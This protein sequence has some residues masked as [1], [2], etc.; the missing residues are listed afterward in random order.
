MKTLIKL[1]WRNIWRNKRRS[2][3]SIAS[4]LFAVLFAITAESF[5]RGSYEHMIKNLVNF[6]TGYIQIQDVLYEDEPSIDNLL[7]YDDELKQILEEFE[8]QIE[9]SVPRLQSFALASTE[10]KTRGAMIFGIDPQKENNF[11]KLQ[12]NLVKGKFLEPDD[13]SIMLTAGLA[14]ILNIDI[15]DTLV[16]IG[17]G[18]QGVNAS[19]MYPVKGIIKLSVPDLNNNTVYLPLKE[20]QW[21]FDAED[22]LSSLIIMPINPNKTVR[23]ASELNIRLDSD[24]YRALT[25]QEMLVDLLKMMEVDA[26]GSKMI[27]YILY[28]VIAFGLFGT[29]LTMMLERIREFAILISIGMKRMQLATICLLESFFLSFI[30]VI[31]GLVI[32][33]PIV[34]YLHLY[35][36]KLS[37]EMAQMMDDYGFDAVMPASLSPEIFYSQAIVIFII[38]LLIGLYPV[39]KVFKLKVIDDAK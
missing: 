34:S 18:F 24:W 33:L 32:T 12:D 7:L 37:G 28:V 22:R 6:S 29:I 20:A 16:L 38:A 23:I 4:V 5:E 11:N 8:D 31:V 26:A 21:F 35:P 15:G 17:Q 39:Y 25:W 10:S 27:I 2:L 30:G 9:F 19:G 13:K 14:S 1:A 36:I 3:I